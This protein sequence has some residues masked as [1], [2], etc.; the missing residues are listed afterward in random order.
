MTHRRSQRQLNKQNENKIRH[1]FI[2]FLEKFV[3]DVQDSYI[4]LLNLDFY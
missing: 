1:G 4:E 3:R 2:F